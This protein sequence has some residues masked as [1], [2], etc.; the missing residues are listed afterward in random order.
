M[1]TAELT[2]NGG[3]VPI[4]DQRDPAWI[5]PPLV[6]GDNDFGSV[7]DTVCKIA[8]TE[9]TKT[10]PGWFLAFGIASSLAGLLGALIAYLIFN[11]VG[12]WGN[13]SPIFWA[14]PIVNFVFWVGIG[15]AGTLI[16]AILFIF[17]Q[18]W[19]TSINRFSE[20]M[21]IFAVVCAGT[22][23]GIHI[24]RV[25][26]G[27]L[28]VSHSHHSPLHVA[29]LPQPAVVGRVCSRHLRLGVAG[30]LVHGHD[31]RPGNAPRPS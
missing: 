4:A 14:F 12:V 7:T 17:R 13:T 31:S 5:N 25:W 15:H 22:F 9:V 1:A 11:G 30:V 6:A 26:F 27:V 21:T 2:A 29:Q 18:N 19:R 3:P 8:E 20:A 16:S 10:P 23:P 24:G 28:P